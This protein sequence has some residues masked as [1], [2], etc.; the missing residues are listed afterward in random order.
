MQDSK[1]LVQNQNINNIQMPQKPMAMA[2]PRLVNSG[3]EEYDAFY[4]TKKKRG[5]FARLFGGI[6]PSKFSEKNVKK[7]IEEYKV[8]IKDKDSVE[9]SIRRYQNSNTNTSET[10]IDA[11]AT[12]AAMGAGFVVKK[13]SIIAN[14]FTPQYKTKAALLTA[15]ASLLTGLVTKLGLKA[16][17][18]AGMN[19]KGRKEQSLSSTALTGGLDGAVGYLGVLNPLFM[20]V[21]LAAS[22][23]SRYM[24]IK[25]NDNKDVSIKD[26][27][28]NQTDAI[29]VGLLGL[30][31][32]SAVAAKGHL[33]IAKIT[34]SIKTAAINKQHTISYHPPENQLTEFQQL[35][36]DIGY[37][38]SIVLNNGKFDPSAIAKLD[39]DFMKILLENGQNGQIDSK[40]QKLELEN[41]FLPKYLQTVIDIP[42]DAQK[43]LCKQIDELVES[44]NARKDSSSIYNGRDWK[45]NY[46][47]YAIDEAMKKLEEKGMDV[48]GFKDLQGILRKIKSKCSASRTL[49]EAQEML[50]SEFGAKYTITKPCGTGSV[51]ETYLAKDNASGE[52]V[53][54]KIIKDYFLREDKITKDRRKILD[55]IDERAKEDF[56]FMTSKQ[57][58]KTPERKKYDVNQTENMFKVW[59]GEIN[60]TQEAEAAN[61]VNSQAK[62]FNAVG[63]IE[64]KNNVFVMKK[65][66]GVQLDSEDFAKKWQEENLT[67][68]DFKNLVEN[69][70]K[71]Y[72]EQLFSIPKTGKKV[73][74]SDPHGGN[75]FID[76]K[77]VKNI[78]NGSK[79]IRIIDYGNTTQTDQTQAIKNL[80]NHL[81]YLVG[82]TESIAEAMLE[83]ANLGNKNKNQVIK[84]LSKALNEAIY[85]PDTKLD[86]DNPVKIFSTVNSFCLDF[87]QKQNIIPNASHINQMKAEETYIISNLGC[88]KNIADVCGYDLKKAVDRDAI[89]KQLVNEM[90]KATEDAMKF[91]PSLTSKEVA[92]RYNFL[93]DNTEEALSCLGINFG[94]I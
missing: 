5:L 41:I 26:F 2:V 6:I 36:R 10:V 62:T 28:Q 68:T 51:A 87:M 77:E 13:T 86:V 47:E 90:T 57:T 8:G 84:D 64:A 83:G 11:L 91:N 59:G 39:E 85:N 25:R 37:D 46:E 66:N 89:I 48:N 52:E 31:G 42:E 1:I 71:V 35:A 14:I 93:V 20:P 49:E 74:Q 18:T 34:D 22:M 15:G 56:S 7:N 76:I 50:N 92:K 72:C 79:P 54:I 53:V 81:D 27:V 60:L 65:A 40:I 9:D 3:V 19:K 21:G 33:N 24:N 63:V 69:Y 70:V 75:I 67:E 88:L 16:I 55:K 38:L 61:V 32:I 29:G 23:L 73:V 30:L 78:L 80:F 45:W 82:N 44:Y 12:S 4:S 17:D 58:I 94:L 43:K